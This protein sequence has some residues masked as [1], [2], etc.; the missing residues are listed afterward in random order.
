MFKNAD[1]ATWIRTIVLAIALINQ[2]LVS[3]GLSQMPFTPAEIEAGLSALFTALA[4]L[5]AWCKN[6]S[7]TDEARRGDTLMN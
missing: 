6:N 5:W 3:I 4:A 7:F 2:I 1:K